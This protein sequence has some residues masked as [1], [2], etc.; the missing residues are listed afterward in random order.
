MSRRLCVA[1]LALLAVACR[2][3]I[4][5]LVCLGDCDSSGSVDVNEIITLVNIALGN[6]DSSA[7][8]HGITA[9]AT[10]DIGLIIQAVNSAL[11]GCPHDQ[12]TATPTSTPTVTP[13]QAPTNPY[14]I[15]APNADLSAL[16]TGQNAM[17]L[18][19][20][21]GTG[22]EFIVKSLPIGFSS[23]YTVSD[24]TNPAQS[25]TASIVDS[26]KFSLSGSF[27]AQGLPGRLTG[28]GWF[29]GGCTDQNGYVRIAGVGFRTDISGT[30]DGTPFTMNFSLDVASNPYLYAA[31]GVNLP[32]A[33]V[34][35]SPTSFRVGDTFS[36][37]NTNMSVRFNIVIS[38][39]GQQVNVCDPDF[40]ATCQSSVNFSKATTTVVGVENVT[41]PAGTFS[42]VRVATNFDTS[43]G[44]GS[45]IRWYAA[46]IGQVKFQTA[47]VSP[48]GQGF[49]VTMGE[50]VSYTRP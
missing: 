6:A 21:R 5:Q 40:G 34:G 38:T 4:G 44:Q 3:A 47:T 41:V 42:A 29:S 28:G 20:N 39:Q 30:A 18:T 7:C 8:P 10:V 12:S 33:T 1:L 32:L 31:I 2:P 24:D 37:S 23:T 46:D 45:D 9:G 16:C 50:L 26:N 35:L 17:P 48:N 15:G 43:V 36:T 22:A 11:N 27:T 25:V 19:Y 49:G 14:L 13:T